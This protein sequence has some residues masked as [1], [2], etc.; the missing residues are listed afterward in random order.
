MSRLPLW[1][2]LAWL[3]ARAPELHVLFAALVI[4]AAAIST[5]GAFAD[6][7]R[8]ALDRESGQLLAADLAVIADHPIPP[9]VVEAARKRGLTTVDLVAFPSMLVHGDTVQLA[10]IKAVSPG[11]PLRGALRIASTPIAADVQATGIPPAGELWAEPS[12]LARLGAKIGDT[13]QVGSSSLRIAAVLRREPDSAFELFNIAPH[14]LLA[15]ADI[16]ATGLIQPGSRVSYR[17]LASGPAAALE[18]FRNAI[19]GTLGRGERIEG[20]RDARPEVRA[21]LERSDRFLGLA[22]VLAVVL[23][24]VAVGVSTRRF[25][26]RQYDPCAVM[27]CMGATQGRLLRLYLAR[28]ALLALAGSIAGC[29]VGY[30]AQ[31]VLASSLATLYTVEL[32]PAGWTPAMQA[33]LA[34]CSLL[35]GFALPPLLTLR[36]VP[37]L[38]VLRRDLGPPSAT[39]WAG[40][41]IGFAS[42]CG[43]IVWRAGEWRLAAYVL[44]GLAGALV[45]AAL[46]A[47]ALLALAGGLRAR[48]A[49]TW[50]YGIAAMRRRAGTS[51]AQTVALALGLMALLLL[52]FVRGDLLSSWQ[53]RLPPD[54][55][56]RFVINIQPDQ[57]EAV[58]AFFASRRVVEPELYPMVRGRLV[59]IRDA[60]VDVQRY[61]DV[62]TRRLAEREFNLSWARTLR[63]DNVVTAG[64]FSGR[65]EKPGFSV[66]EG[67]AQRLGIAVGDRL[68]FD[69]A[70]TP[71]SATVTSLRKLDWDS[72]KVNFFVVASP[73]LLDAAT[74]SYI[75]SFHLPIGQEKLIDEL[76]RR[77]DNLT[78][79]DAAAIVRQVQEMTAQVAR[80]LEF[81][82][83]FSLGSGIVVLFAAMIATQDER[84]RETALLRTLGARGRQIL[85]SQVA[86]FVALGTIAGLVGS[87]GAVGI[88][89]VVATRVLAVG[90]RFDPLVPLVGI[91]GG[92]AAIV[93]TGLATTRS[94]LRIAPLEALRRFV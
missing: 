23:S 52:T 70:G 51:V 32:P 7:V 55:P 92:I 85:G 66:E 39:S 33:V 59:A 73:G 10:E 58:R 63:A 24:A 82:F 89:Y 41:L 29:T 38:R 21:T 4:A 17:L 53:S 76:V 26:Q 83:L 81:V 12:L 90:F 34:V 79:V 56:N 78:V 40:Y 72:F 2:K 9:A 28:F 54:A 94:L 69:V 30:V 15:I 71:V 22:A 16:P 87:T 31:H 91:V 1:L 25:V 57:V 19:S 84:L 50:R 61:D 20:I 74:T 46:L 64:Q 80:A 45:V 65:A 62:R 14:A 75:T 27:R 93:L 88:G 5:V 49:G 77:F 37:T 3:G 86:E 47:L 6:R 42:L 13:V 11:Y 68:T 36:D 43:L 18:A 48:T 8:G 60:P 67:I 44:G 35:F